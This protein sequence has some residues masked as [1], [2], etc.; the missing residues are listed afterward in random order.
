MDC[1]KCAAGYVLWV[2]VRQHNRNS[3]YAQG[4][5]LSCSTKSTFD[6]LQERLIVNRGFRI[7]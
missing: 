7:L 6:S 2:T 4:V 1:G 5:C 3:D